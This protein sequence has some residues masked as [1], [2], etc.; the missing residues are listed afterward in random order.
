[1]NDKSPLSLKEVFSFIS[2]SFAMTETMQARGHITNLALSEADFTVCKNSLGNEEDRIALEELISLMW[3]TDNEKPLSPEDIPP[4]LSPFGQYIWEF[5]HEATVIPHG[6]LRST[7]E[8][9]LEESVAN[10]DFCFG[11]WLNFPE[12]DWISRK[13]NLDLVN[14]S[15]E[16]SW[17]GSLE[18][19]PDLNFGDPNAANPPEIQPPLLEENQNVLMQLQGL[20]YTVLFMQCTS[21]LIFIGG[22]GTL[23]QQLSGTNQDCFTADRGISAGESIAGFSRFLEISKFRVL[24]VLCLDPELS[25]YRAL[26]NIAAKLLEAGWLRTVQNIEKYLIHIIKLFADCRSSYLAVVSKILNCSMNAARD[27]RMDDEYR[28]GQ[29]RPDAE[30]YNPDYIAR[31]QEEEATACGE[32]TMVSVCTTYGPVAGSNAQPNV[33]MSDSLDKG[34]VLGSN[35]GHQRISETTSPTC[36]SRVNTSSTDS[37]LSQGMPLSREPVRRK[38]DVEGCGKVYPGVYCTD[39]LARHKREKHTNRSFFTC[40]AQ[41]CGHESKRLH[42]LRVHWETKHKSMPMPEWLIGGSSCGESVKR[43]RKHSMT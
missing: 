20:M 12:D 41:S 14:L 6:S 3:Q 2:L 36:P 29:D 11:D 17:I 15:H 22:M 42:N 26:F 43:K 1:M 9:L 18:I 10:K 27:D 13:G 28:Y 33:D 32:D 40:S 37:G 16:A 7:A 34:H 31:R 38:C 19:P 30:L 21:F 39:A 5:I 35:Y 8:R 24:N 25:K 4:Y 23:L